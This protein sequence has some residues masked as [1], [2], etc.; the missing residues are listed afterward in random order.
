M[1][2]KLALAFLFLLVCSVTYSQTIKEL[3][4]RK[5]KTEE[6]I[7]LT[8]QLLSDTEQKRVKS[9]SEI[10]LLKAKIGLRKKLIE[11][12]DKQVALVEAEISDKNIV[13]KGL[14]KDVQNLKK[15]YAKLIRFAWRNRTKMQILVFIFSSDD[16]SQAYRRMRFYQQLLNFRQKQGNE[17]IQTQQLLNEEIDKLRMHKKKLEELKGDKSNE[18]TTLNIE[19]KRFSSSVSQL[20]AKERE[21]RKELEERRKSMEALNKAIEALIAEE[22][23]KA[24]ELKTANVRDARYL[25]LSDGFAGNKGRLP[26]PTTQGVVVS[27]FGEHNH[28]VLK[29]V[30][31]KNNGIDISTPANSKVKA[32]YEG[33][34]KKIVTIPGSNVAVIIR[35]GDYLTVYS[36][37]AKVFVKVGDSVS[38]TKEIGEVYT[39][40]GTG[41]GMINLQIWHESQIQNPKSWIL[42]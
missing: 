25:K 32:L 38:A 1:S 31:I 35:H 21:L 9:L 19:E 37:L 18:I 26:W 6:E 8:N 28:P 20:R 22:A 15:E 24:A 42:P 40:P 13:I 2:T 10:N 23:R 5:K 4:E 36:N 11:D 34:V 39:D 3:E 17:I 29:G 30:K 27:E 33:E 7:N 12:I 16:F 41:K 14:E